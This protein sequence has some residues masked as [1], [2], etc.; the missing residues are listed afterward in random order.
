MIATIA[1]I[2][3]GVCVTI[4]M[5]TVIA[6]VGNP[7]VGI[8]SVHGYTITG[9]RRW[10]RSTKNH[11][12]FGNNKLWTKKKN[13]FV[14][15]IVSKVEIRYTFLP[16]GMVVLASIISVIQGFALFAEKSCQKSVRKL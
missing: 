14:N 3:V 4:S 8:R 6:L 15:I 2:L 11:L 12:Q 5:K 1:V 7:R 16:I 13:A 9:L 10:Q